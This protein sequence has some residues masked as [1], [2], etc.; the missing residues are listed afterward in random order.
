MTEST[1]GTTTIVTVPGTDRQIVVMGHAHSNLRKGTGHDIIKS[2]LKDHQ[3]LRNAA[4]RGVDLQ[5]VK[6][7]SGPR[8]RRTA[9]TGVETEERLTREP[10]TKREVVRTGI[11]TGELSAIEQKRNPGMTAVTRRNPPTQ[12]LQRSVGDLPGLQGTMLGISP[13]LHL[14]AKVP[15]LKDRRGTIPRNSRLN[16]HLMATAV[17]QSPCS[18][19]TE[20]LPG[21]S[22]T[23][24]CSPWTSVASGL[25]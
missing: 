11:E 19:N 7:T 16:R 24:A 3:M 10:R 6:M 2:T 17:L 8:A 13:I 1:E 9:L 21:A 25:P 12:D 23:P 15:P 18:S 22:Q 5:T 4:E 14:R 20:R